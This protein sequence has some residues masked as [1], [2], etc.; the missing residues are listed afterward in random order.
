[1]KEVVAGLEGRT[2]KLYSDGLHV[3][4]ERYVLTKADDN[5]NLY[6]RKVGPKMFHVVSFWEPLISYFFHVMKPHNCLQTLVIQTNAATTGKG[7]RCYCQDY[8]S[9]SHCSLRRW[10][11]CW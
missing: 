2:D 11:D 9:Y 10:N 6:A 8:T 7:R 4:G 3:A 5:R 1:M